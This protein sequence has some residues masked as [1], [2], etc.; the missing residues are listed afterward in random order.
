[1]QA[2]VAL[3]REVDDPVGRAW[4]LIYLGWVEND[5]GHSAAG[6]PHLEESLALSR[7]LGDD[8]GVAWSLARLGLLAMFQGEWAAAR[9]PFEESLALS[10]ALGDRWGTAWCLHLLACLY[11]FSGRGDPA[12]AL[13]VER[14]SLA[15]WQET[16]N[17]RD[18]AYTWWALGGIALRQPD[19]ARARGYFRQALPIQAEIGDKFGMLLTLAC[20][21]T[22]AAMAHEHER[23]ACLAAAAR[24]AAER[25]GVPVPDFARALLDEHLARSRRSVGEEAW[26]AA[27]ERGG[28]L[29]L[30]QAVAYALA[31]A[32]AAA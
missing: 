32:P 17:R 13:R 15:I 26:T 29:S 31:A 27:E 4:A 24:A 14:E 2:S 7:A 5:S 12:E 20:W 19:P 8:L 1:L 6:R 9:P 11:V 28:A 16:G 3:S 18:L 30:E 25:T 21:A 22:A 10:R 23:A